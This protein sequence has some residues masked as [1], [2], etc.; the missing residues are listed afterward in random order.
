LFWIIVFILLHSN[1]MMVYIRNIST[2]CGV[3]GEVNGH[4]HLLN[5]C[6]GFFTVTKF[7]SN[8]PVTNKAWDKQI[9]N[10]DFFITLFHL[11]AKENLCFT[12]LGGIMSNWASGTLLKFHST[13]YF[14]SLVIDNILLHKKVK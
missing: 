3:A 8:L 7:S 11:A 5:T 9:A 4:I 14:Y 1:Y 13:I 10:P 6:L 12:I 2:I